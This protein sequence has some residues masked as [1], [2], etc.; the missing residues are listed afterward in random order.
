MFQKKGVAAW[1]GAV[2]RSDGEDSQAGVVGDLPRR[3][4]MTGE[5]EPEGEVEQAGGQPQTGQGLAGP[6]SRRR[7]ARASEYHTKGT[8]GLGRLGLPPLSD[9]MERK[10][11]PANTPHPG[12]L[13]HLGKDTE[14][15]PAPEV[16]VIRSSRPWLQEESERS[17]REA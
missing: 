17:G 7:H 1:V 4:P 14:S 3:F 12:D 16:L 5:G 11:R 8:G 10:V 6:D 2:G 13:A 9:Q 15:P